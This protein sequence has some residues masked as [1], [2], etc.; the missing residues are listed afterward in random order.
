[1][2]NFEL[3]S[4]LFT[5]PSFEKNFQSSIDKNSKLRV[6]MYTL[7]QESECEKTDNAHVIVNCVKLIDIAGVK[8]ASG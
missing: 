7:K 8:T 6:S 4:I 2:H 5:R 3:F 1:M